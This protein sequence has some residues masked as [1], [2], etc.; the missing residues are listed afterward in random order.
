VEEF[1]GLVHVSSD[2]R[3]EAVLLAHD[4]PTE[5]ASL[6]CVQAPS[7]SC[8]SVTESE[9]TSWVPAIGPPQKPPNP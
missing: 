2:F 4:E 9:G 5:A 8:S 6:T 3:A 7:L 1:R